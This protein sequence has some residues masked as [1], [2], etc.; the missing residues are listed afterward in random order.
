MHTHLCLGTIT[1]RVNWTHNLMHMYVSCM[2][3]LKSTS[4]V[5]MESYL[6]KGEEGR[7]M[8]GREERERERERN[9]CREG[10]KR[11]ERLMLSLVAM[12]PIVTSVCRPQSYNMYNVVMYLHK[13]VSSFM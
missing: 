1:Q 12:E 11:G 2:F 7:E 10:E 6:K 4:N 3:T 8:G 5:S 9:T 13:L